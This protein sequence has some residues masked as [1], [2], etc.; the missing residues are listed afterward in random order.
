MAVL[1]TP[2]L[3]N[4]GSSLP[5]RRYRARVKA[6]KEGRGLQGHTEDCPTKTIFP[7]AWII[8]PYP[9]ASFPIVV[10]SFP[11]P[12]NVGSRRPLGSYR[13]R[14][15]PEERQSDGRHAEPTATI[16]PSD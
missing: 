14:A 8:T 11:L 1:T 6:V 16:F 3:P 15:K 12:P 2:R 7:F 9:S 5:F 4:K 13:A 10:L